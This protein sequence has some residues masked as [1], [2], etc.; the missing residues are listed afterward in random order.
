[1]RSAAISNRVALGHKAKE[2]F[3]D[4]DFLSS[5]ETTTKSVANYR[6][7]FSKSRRMLEKTLGMTIEPI[8]LPEAK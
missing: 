8:P 2:L 4:N 5:I 3:A 7:R 1:M 6:T